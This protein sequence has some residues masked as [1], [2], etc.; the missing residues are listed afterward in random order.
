MKFSWE[1]RNSTAKNRKARIFIQ[2]S[3]MF[4][5]KN[6]IQFFNSVIFNIRS[7]NQ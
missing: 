1:K 3:F 6:L 5:F 4:E 7:I 2:A